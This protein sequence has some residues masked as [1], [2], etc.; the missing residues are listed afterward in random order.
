MCGVQTDLLEQAKVFSLASLF[1]LVDDALCR[2][3]I[4][5]SQD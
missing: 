3:K 4:L 5:L 2:E 1:T